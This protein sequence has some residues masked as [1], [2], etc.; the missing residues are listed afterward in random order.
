MNIHEGK[1]LG[2]CSLRRPSTLKKEMNHDML[3]QT[4]WYVRPAKAQTSLRILCEYSVS[5]KLLT[6]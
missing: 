3:F 2:P 5:V 4:M 6:E 1:G